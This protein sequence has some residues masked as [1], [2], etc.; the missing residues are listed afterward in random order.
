M[1][2]KGEIH[3]IRIF[4]ITVWIVHYLKRAL[5]VFYVQKFSDGKNL[6]QNVSF[7]F[8]DFLLGHAFMGCRYFNLILKSFGIIAVS[9]HCGALIV[10]ISVFAHIF[11]V[12]LLINPI[13]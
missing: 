4:K 11:I 8:V 3:N 5:G 12:L 13:Y 1:N 9:K 7:H 10:T 2:F 6:F